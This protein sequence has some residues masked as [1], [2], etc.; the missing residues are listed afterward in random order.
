[1]IRDLEFTIATTS[2]ASKQFQQSGEISNGPCSE[3]VS[4]SSEVVDPM[5]ERAIQAPSMHI[6]RRYENPNPSRIRTRQPFRFSA[7][8]SYNV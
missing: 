7:I 2:A 8:P 1:M 3:V 5:P 6:P 4:A